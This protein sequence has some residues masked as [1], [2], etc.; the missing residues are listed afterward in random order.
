M[1][2]S[3][4]ERVAKMRARRKKGRLVISVEVDKGDLREIA[5]AGYPDAASTT[6]KPTERPP[7]FS[8]RIP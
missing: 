7:V 5:G 2:T 8:Y 4:K 3:S 6:A 1:A